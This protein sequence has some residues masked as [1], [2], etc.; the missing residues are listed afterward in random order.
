MSAHQGETRF[1]KQNSAFLFK[2]I[3]HAWL[4]IYSGCI[5]DKF[6]NFFRS[7]HQIAHS[8]FNS[9]MEFVANENRNP[10]S[11]ESFFSFNKLTERL[12]THDILVTFSQKIR[13]WWSKISFVTSLCVPLVTFEWVNG[14][15]LFFFLSSVCVCLVSHLRTHHCHAKTFQFE[16]QMQFIKFFFL[17]ICDCA[18][19]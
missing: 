16:C 5:L 7:W 1:I 6:G 3:E 15:L 8:P 19:F 12:S 14:F 17:V 13:I 18:T 11:T 9:F 10:S 2:C 4:C